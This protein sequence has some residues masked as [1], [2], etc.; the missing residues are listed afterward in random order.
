MVSMS[1]ALAAGLPQTPSPRWYVDHKKVPQAGLW[2]GI[3]YC[4]SLL[5][6]AAATTDSLSRSGPPRR[7]G[8]AG[9]N[10]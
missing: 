2:W 6:A 5:V 8:A 10:D 9:G 7:C 3:D 1:P 4:W